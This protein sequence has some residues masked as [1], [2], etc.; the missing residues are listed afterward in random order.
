MGRT[1]S[2]ELGIVCNNNCRFCYQRNLR[3]VRDYPKKLPLQE[4]KRKLQWGRDNGYIHVGFE[5]GEPTVRADILD[6]IKSAKTMGYRRIGITTNGRRLA[7]PDFARAIVKAG[8]NGVGFSIHGPDAATHQAHTMRRRSFEQA[9][10]GIRNIVALGRHRRIDLNIFTVVTRK[11]ADKLTDIGIMF[12]KLGIRLLILQPLTYSKGNF[13]GMQDLVLPMDELVNAIRKAIYAGMKNDFHV[14]L[15]NLPVCLFSDILPGLEMNP[16]PSSVFREDEKGKA[17]ELSDQGNGYV[18]PGACKSCE[19]RSICPGI[20]LSLLPQFDLVQS[21]RKAVNYHRG[22]VDELWLPGMEMAGAA[23]T[24]DVVRHAVS[25]GYRAI[26]LL[27]GGTFV[28]PLSYEA[29]IRAG[30]DEIILVHRPRDPHS[31]DRLLHFQGNGPFLLD[32]LSLIRAR[33]SDVRL[34]LFSPPGEDLD[35]LL[36]KIMDTDKTL[37]TIRITLSG[38]GIHLCSPKGI[39]Y[40]REVLKKIPR[41]IVELE[42]D[43]IVKYFPCLIFLAQVSL[44]RAGFHIATDKCL[45]SGFSMPQYGMLNWSDPFPLDLA[46]PIDALRI[47]ATSLHVQPISLKK[48]QEAAILRKLNQTTDFRLI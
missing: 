29:A 1:L 41:V 4:V 44:G 16:L 25:S 13:T 22:P 43:E 10:A 35:R 42:R 8:L 39:R 32:T 19:I 14:K 33:S 23:A 40:F 7:N 28:N 9:M 37:R 3:R 27:T 38:R 5:G 12:R 17:G 30:V 6:I 2:I 47:T 45:R 26:K 11:N 31:G 18:R 48:L 24:F 20:P 21:M 46:P 36:D 15:F 34:S